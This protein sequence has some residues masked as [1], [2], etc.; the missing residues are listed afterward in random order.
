MSISILFFTTSSCPKC[1]ELYP[2]LKSLC[3]SKII[4]VVYIDAVESRLNMDLANAFHVMEAPT[5]VVM[6]EGKE[7]VR[8]GH[9]GQEELEK[10]IN[11]HRNDVTIIDIALACKIQNLSCGGVRC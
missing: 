9:V 6:K 1:K 4:T 11:A 10:I 8:F 2:R 7:V 5:S 3:D